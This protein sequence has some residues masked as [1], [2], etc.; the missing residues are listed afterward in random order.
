MTLLS[1]SSGQ[2][3]TDLIGLI[4]YAQ[5]SEE[6]IL[7]TCSSVISGM[8]RDLLL[9]KVLI[10]MLS[11]SDKEIPFCKTSLASDYKDT[12]FVGHAEILE[13]Q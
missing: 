11:V 3:S 10:T 7:W 6:D 8:N 5:R 12:I 1:I 2:N 13:Q 4:A 9:W